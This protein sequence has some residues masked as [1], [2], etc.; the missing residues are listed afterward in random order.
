MTRLE[1]SNMKAVFPVSIVRGG[2]VSSPS[3]SSKQMN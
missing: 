1:Q 2:I 3:V